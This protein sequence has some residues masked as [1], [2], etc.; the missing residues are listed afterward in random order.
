M[1]DEVVSDLGPLSVA[2]NAV[3]LF[4]SGPKPFLDL[5]LDEWD[6]A[7]TL[8][9]HTALLCMQAEA[10]AMVKHD[11]AGRIV[12]FGSSNGVVGA[13]NISHYGAANAGVIHL[14]KSA[15]MELGGYNIRVNCV[16]PV[17]ISPMASDGCWMIRTPHRRSAS[18]SGWPGAAP[19]LGRLGEPLGDRGRCSVPG[20]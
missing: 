3:G 9:L 13:P 19:P 4:H 17:R 20:V 6:D 1:I 7:F 16:V 12:N 2:I 10:V 11:V 15:A 5:T 8:Q 18:S 14:T